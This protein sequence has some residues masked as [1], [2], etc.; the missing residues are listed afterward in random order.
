MATL[1]RQLEQSLD[2]S[3]EFSIN[4]RQSHLNEFEDDDLAMYPSVEIAELNL[5]AHQCEILAT[6]IIAAISSADQN[7]MAKPARALVT[8]AYNSLMD[9][10]EGPDQEHTADE[11]PFFHNSQF[12]LTEKWLRICDKSDLDLTDYLTETE[13]EIPK[14][15]LIRLDATDFMRKAS[16]GA[17]TYYHLR[18]MGHFKEHLWVKSSSDH[19]HATMK[20]LYGFDSVYEF[21]HLSKLNYALLADRLMVNKSGETLFLL[22]RSMIIVERPRPDKRVTQQKCLV[23][24]LAFS[25]PRGLTEGRLWLWNWSKRAAGKKNLNVPV[26]RVFDQL[27]WALDQLDKTDPAYNRYTRFTRGSIANLREFSQ[28]YVKIAPG[29]KLMRSKY[30]KYARLVNHFYFD[31]LSLS[32]NRELICALIY[33][34]ENMSGDIIKLRP[35]RQ[36]WKQ[37]GDEMGSMIVAK[38][39]NN[40]LTKTNHLTRKFGR[41]SV[42][43]REGQWRSNQPSV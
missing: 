19:F 37:W 29:P 40:S 32:A 14:L 24:Q 35:T 36:P 1:L 7:S 42:G 11:I 15:Q 17:W 23:E 8:L 27:E 43:D 25:H 33:V 12:K 28:R 5:T 38:N 13:D 10:G 9:P 34:I 2:A 39:N 6:N 21:P 16:I 18:L 4:L 26:E 41:I 30:F 31:S 22:Y 20:E 3:D